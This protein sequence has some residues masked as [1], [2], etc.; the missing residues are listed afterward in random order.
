MRYK[1]I[2]GPAHYASAIAVCRHYVIVIRTR[3]G[4]VVEVKT[5]YEISIYR[6][7]S[8]RVLALRVRSNGRRGSGAVVY[9][10]KGARGRGT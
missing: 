3:L 9:V 10:W 2:R 7:S 6:C 8:H 4:P 1:A 5:G